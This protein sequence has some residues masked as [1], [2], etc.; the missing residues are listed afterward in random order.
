MELPLLGYIF[1]D[2]ALW[3]DEKKFDAPGLRRIT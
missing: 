3:S 2:A 1:D